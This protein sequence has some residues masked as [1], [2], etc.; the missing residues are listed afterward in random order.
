MA[1]VTNMKALAVSAEH[2]ERRDLENL[3]LTEQ[4]YESLGEM[5]EE[6]EVIDLVDFE[7]I[8]NDNDDDNQEDTI[9]RT[10]FFTFILY[11]L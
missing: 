7:D 3:Y 5:F 11:K 10:H 8:L 6:F 4:T 1:A 2:G 9:L